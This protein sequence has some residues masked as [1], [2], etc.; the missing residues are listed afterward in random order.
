MKLRFVVLTTTSW[1]WVRPK[2]SIGPPRQAAQEGGAIGSTPAASK[3]WRRLWPSIVVSTSPCS[4]TRVAGTSNVRTAT[5][6]PFM[7]RAAMTK[8]SSLP[9]VQEPM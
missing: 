1:P 9:P 3:I 2:V 6:R 8:S 5:F 4:T 7:I